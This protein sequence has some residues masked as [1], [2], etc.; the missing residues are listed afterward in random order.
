M[1]GSVDRTKN[2]IV[3]QFN[4][5][6]STKFGFSIGEKIDPYQMLIAANQLEMMAKNVIVMLEQQRIAQ[7]Q[8]NKIQVAEPKIVIAK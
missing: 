5:E 6:G 1:E 2:I 3:I 8:M 4:S 7:E